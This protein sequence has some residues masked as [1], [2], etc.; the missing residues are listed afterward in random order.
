MTRKQKQIYELIKTAGG[1][2]TKREI[3]VCLKRD[4][5]SGSAAQCIGARLTRMVRSGY[6]E[7]YKR[8]RYKIVPSEKMRS[9]QVPP[10][11]LDLF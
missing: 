4:Y 2:L 6:L 1:Y 8:G 5:P 9:P 3:V 7:R 10:N 11:Q